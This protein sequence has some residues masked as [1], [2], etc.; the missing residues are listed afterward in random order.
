MD[1]E[2]EY[3]GGPADG[4]RERIPTGSDGA[5]PIWRTVTSLP[6]WR[7]ALDRGP[8][9]PE[10]VEAYDREPGPRGNALVWRYHHRGRVL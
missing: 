7:S 2:V 1:V 4:R 3:L 10:S 8:A 5:P 6:L 9:A